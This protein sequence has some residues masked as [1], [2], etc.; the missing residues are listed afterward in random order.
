[1]RWKQGMAHPIPL[2]LSGLPGRHVEA[3][4]GTT[5]GA[6]Y[7][8]TGAT[9]IGG[10]DPHDAQQPEV[11]FFTLP[12]VIPAGFQQGIEPFPREWRIKPIFVHPLP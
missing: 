11:F 5:V 2:S 1:M 4:D 7:H 12:G 10:D 9:H 8:V 3:E 6:D